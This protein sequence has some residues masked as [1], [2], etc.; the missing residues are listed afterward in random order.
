MTGSIHCRN[1]GAPADPRRQRCE[2]CGAWQGFEPSQPWNLLFH[3]RKARR[4]FIYPLLIAAGCL[5]MFYIYGVAFDRLSETTLV[6][7][8]PLWFFLI[9]FGIYGYVAEKLLAA[10]YAGESADVPAALGKWLRQTISRHPLFGIFAAVLLFPFLLIKAK[11]SLPVAFIGSMLWGI[12][13]LLF[14]VFAF[15]AL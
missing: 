1:C 6:R 3:S 7:L 14:F 15:P 2:Y 4:R 13:L 10:V 12:L 5:L 9:V 8:T 11:S